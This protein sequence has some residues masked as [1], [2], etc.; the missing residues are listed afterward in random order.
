MAKQNWLKSASVAAVAVAAPFALMGAAQ[1]QEDTI[2]VTGSFIQGTPEDAALPVD[3]I[4]A[5]ELAEVGNPT[6]NDILRNLPSAQGL[7]GETNQFDTRGG[8]GNLGVTTINLR[9]LGSSRTLVLLNGKRH[10]A[11]QGIGVDVTVMPVSAIQRLEV[12]KD[13]AA[14]LYGSDAIAGVVN[15]ITRDDFQGL[16]ISGNYTDIQDT[17]GQYQIA[18]ITGWS[19]AADTA[20]FMLAA[21]YEE[22]SELT[23]PDRD[24]ALPAFA[25]NPQAGG[26]AIGNPGT[27]IDL[28]TGAFIGDPNCTALGSEFVAPFCRFQF[29]RFDNL[30]EDS[31]T[32]K[33][34]GTASFDFGNDNTFRLEAAYSEVDMP[35]AATS[36]SYPPQS[37][38][39]AAS[40][41]PADHPAFLDFQASNPGVF[42]GAPVIFVGRIAGVAGING[43]DNQILSYNTKQTRFGAGLSGPLNDNMNYDF[44]ITYSERNRDQGFTDTIQE[45]FSLA[46]RGF[47]GPNCDRVNGSA[48]VGGCQYF[49]PFSSAIESSV[50]TGANAAF[51][52]A[53]ANSPELFN[54]LLDTGVSETDTELLV[55]DAVIDGQTGWELGG[56][57]VGYAYGFQLRDESFSLDIT[58]NFNLNLNPC[59]FNDPLSV[60]LGI[61]PTLDCVAQ[62]SVTGR[63]AFLAG[64]FPDELDR[65]VYGFFGE[66]AL[67]IT[68]RLDVQI[69]A[70]FE[71]YGDNGGGDTF[72]PKIA[73]RWQAT[74]NIALRGSVSST[75]R[76]PELNALLGR[77][78]SLQ[79]I[80]PT[81]AFKAVDTVA[82]PD[83]EP[84]SAIASNIGI[85]YENENFR[86]SLDYYRFDFE[87]P[88]QLESADQI[89]NA[90]TANGCFDGGGNE[91]SPVCQSLRAQ[92]SPTG[93]APA[94]I[95]RIIRQTIN[96]SDVLTEGL[97]F[98][99]EYSFSADG[100][101]DFKVGAEGTYTLKYEA[102]DFVNA[103]GVLLAPGGDFE[104]QL[105]VGTPFQSIV[106]LRANAFATVEKGPHKLNYTLRYVDGIDDARAATIA[107]LQSIDSHITHDVTYN[108][109]LNDG[110]TRLFASVQNFTDEDPPAAQLELNYDPFTHNPF[111]RIIKVG[112]T[113]DFGWGQ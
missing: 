113:H 64:T 52:P 55:I 44:S 99:G 74:D 79:F 11:A 28:G 9:G 90:Y 96:G 86:G 6:L 62:D 60:T 77:T 45:E 63:F 54:S 49:N 37:P 83:L 87:D 66:M 48:G 73:A 58:D 88:F 41:V 57:N 19:N 33:L 39:G 109:E 14:A 24:F 110:Q 56:G 97:D 53:F 22:R 95:Q 3:V 98:F 36:P 15:F 105:N 108:L 20:R 32:F 71:D 69:A 91:A 50:I 8:Q 89:V 31:E 65:T 29:S 68:D 85:L 18:G 92:V 72:D 21:E 93:T 46:L 47:G 7:I 94:G 26:S 25:D 16:E 35:E 112:F 107:S 82:N 42:T 10:V 17:D 38:F 34:F 27:F 76:G 78:T 23:V 40:L 5:D 106:E 80:G 30:I 102:D 2:V 103:D 111:G 4:G 1:A 61:T 43:G 70:R 13:G 75:F 84:E 12:L 67:P 51:N 59:P 104:G 101:Y 81:A 100:G